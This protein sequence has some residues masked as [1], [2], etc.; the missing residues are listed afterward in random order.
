MSPAVATATLR[1]ASSFALRLDGPGGSTTGL[2]SAASGGVFTADVIQHQSG[3]DPFPRKTLGKPRY[4]DIEIE[5]GAAMPA[6]L[7][8]WIAAS[9][10]AS[11]PSMDGAVL[12]FDSTFTLRRE[13]GFVDALIAET[14]FP[15]LDAASKQI[16]RIGVRIT[17]RELLPPT[18]PA[19]GTKLN[20][21][22]GKS[23]HKAWQVAAFKLELDGLPTSHVARIDAFAVRRTI[24]ISQGQGSTIKPGRIAFP[25]LRV[26]LAA[27]AADAWHAWHKHFL[28]DGHSTDADEKAGAIVL[29]SPNF[30]PIATIELHGVGIFR[31]AMAPQDPEG[32]P[33]STVQRVVA[34][35]YCERMRLLAGGA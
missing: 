2:V 7:F 9:W 23:P 22:L 1:V 10:G 20:L 24:E 35:L 28:I 17:P 34:D 4:E 15:T 8:D 16:G 26:W 3:G 31:I 18:N 5:A 25:N 29:L 13:Q 11:P 30:S 32:G 27:S 14:A 21:P 19:P 6:A 12:G 33:A